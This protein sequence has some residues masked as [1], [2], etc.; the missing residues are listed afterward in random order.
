MSAAAPRKT[1]S[2]LRVVIIVMV[3]LFGVIL[4]CGLLSVIAIPAMLSYAKRAKTAEAEHYLD[5]LYTSAASYYAEE[6]AL[7]DGTMIAG[8][9]VDSA[10]TDN[11]P[12]TAV[13]VMDSTTLPASFQALGVSFVDPIRFRYEIVSAGGCN[14]E[15][16]A[17]VYTFRAHGD[18]DGDGSQSL[19]ELSAHAAP[20]NQLERV[21]PITRVD[22]L[23]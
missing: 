15:P 18:L 19:F 21:G 5:E 2:G 14:H 6:H 9:A 4:L 3:A 12:G 8:C 20:G 23:E 7:P 10:S 22:E 17:N 16:R 13:T 11:T 1:S